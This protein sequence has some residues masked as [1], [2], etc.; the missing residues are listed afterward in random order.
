MAI[1]YTKVPGKYVDFD[2]RNLKP[3][4]TPLDDHV[5]I[6]AQKTSSGSIPEKQPT[7]VFSD[8]DAAL[9]F[10]SGSVAHLAVREALTANP[11]LDLTV[12][13]VDDAG[14][15]VKAEGQID[16]AGFTG[17]GGVNGTLQVFIGDQMIQAAYSTTDTPTSLALALD[18]AASVYS[19]VLPVDTTAISSTWGFTAKNAGTVGN[20]IP[21][22]VADKNGTSYVTVTAMTT[23]STDPDVGNYN[24]AGSVLASV[25]AGNYTV[26]VNGIPNTQGSHDSATKIKT[27]LDWAGGSVEQRGAVQVLAVPDIEETYANSKTLAGTSLNH[28]RTTLCRDVYADSTDA[29]IA[30]SEYFKEAA[31][32]GAMIA[33]QTDPAVPYDGLA[34]TGIAPMAVPE[35]LSFTQMQDL[36]SN[37][38][39]PLNVISGEQVAIV[40]AISTYITTGGVPDYT[41][42]DI[43]TC[44]TMDYLRTQIRTRYTLRFVRAK[45]SARVLKS[46][47]TE[48]MDV[49]Y[50]LEK[51]EIVQN[52]QQY[53]SGVTVVKDNADPYRAV[54]TIPA[55]IVPGLHVIAATIQLIL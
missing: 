13:G 24:S 10:G 16:L 11:N 51:A 14:G 48:T 29:G 28:W 9:Y 49:L 25:A 42:I 32:Y 21:I 18:S 35:R 20:Y 33:S 19:N 37:G 15:A 39:S 6:I 26:V 22:R 53:E 31:A 50:Q 8:A 7:K 45:M 55:N 12:V 47:K 34:L 46:I 40:R 30:R 36:L 52:V 41:L 4:L 38:V 1:P 44:R 3:G 17:L 43:N 2:L 5:L 27:W 54:V 23:G